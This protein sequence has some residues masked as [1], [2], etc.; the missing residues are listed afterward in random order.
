ML[1]I[2]IAIFALGYVA[3]VLAQLLNNSATA[4]LTGGRCWAIYALT[5][6]IAASC[7]WALP[8]SC[9]MRRIAT[10]MLWVGAARPV[11]LIAELIILSLVSVIV[12][13]SWIDPQ[14]PYYASRDMS[15]PVRRS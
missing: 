9:A 4:L 14:S 8:L 7:S 10:I 11:H 12:F 6:S 3:I 1:A 15:S 13:R 5:T 2:I